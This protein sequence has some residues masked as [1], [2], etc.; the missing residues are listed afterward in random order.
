MKCGRKISQQ[1]FPYPGN[2]E[3]SRLCG[4]LLITR[5]GRFV[6]VSLPLPNVVFVFCQAEPDLLCAQRSSDSD[7]RAR[8]AGHWISEKSA[9]LFC[10]VLIKM[11]VEGFGDKFWYLCWYVTILLFLCH[12]NVIVI[13]YT[14]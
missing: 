10:C 8:I 6:Y 3:S 9:G 2:K 14:S 5:S 13:R 11:Y 12:W 1:T 4:S 7:S